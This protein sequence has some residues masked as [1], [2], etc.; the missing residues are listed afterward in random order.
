M[1]DMGTTAIV[2]ISQVNHTP[3]HTDAFIRALQEAGIRAVCAYSRGGPG[4]QY[5][6]DVVRLRRTYFSSQDQLLTLAL[7]T[8]VD[9]KT[10]EYARQVG[11]RSVLHIRVNPSR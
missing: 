3:E 10:F 7:A 5:P 9:P 8:S 4:S 1:I 6:Q 11:V 2:D